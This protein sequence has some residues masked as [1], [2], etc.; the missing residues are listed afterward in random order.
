[1]TG[2]RALVLAGSRPEIDPLLAYADVPHKSLITLQGQTL[3]ARVVD[4]LTVSGAA[5]IGVCTSHP[6]VI[7]A[8]GRIAT[9][10]RLEIIPAADS[11]SQSVGQGAQAMGFPLLVT[12]ADHALLRPEWVQAFL[13]GVPD[14]AD[15]AALLAPEALVR[16]AAPGGKRTYLAFRDGRYSGC[17]LFY[18]RSEAALG[19][20]A[21]WRQVEARRKQPWKIAALLGPVML[22]AYLTG[23]LTLDQ[24]V[25]RLG[26][27]AGVQARAVRT[28][29]GLAAVDVDKPADLD[30]VRRLTAPEAAL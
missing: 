17:N 22:L 27:K 26:R 24:A 23:R 11:P 29:H 16:A 28:R 25:A 4:A 12:T 10:A 1:M 15:I 30:L 19:A 21:L 9:S 13:A 3:L 14:E 5:S 6:A 8:A 7:E 20:V 18:L 2:F